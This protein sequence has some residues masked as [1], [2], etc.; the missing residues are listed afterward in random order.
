MESP[1]IAEQPFLERLRDLALHLVLP[2]G[3]LAAGLLPVLV[4]HVRA[5]MIEVLDAP[6]ALSARAQGI[7]TSRLLFRHLLPAAVNP[8]IS[9]FGLTVGTMLSASLLIEVVM[10]WP[11]LGPLMV[12][13]IMARDIAVVLGVILLSAAFLVAGNLLADL[14]LYRLDPRIRVKKW[15]PGG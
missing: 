10:G 2:A 5:A 3:V 11:G 7:P 14:L 1:G 15:T 13:A 4:Q 6:F 9:L 12:E 8:L